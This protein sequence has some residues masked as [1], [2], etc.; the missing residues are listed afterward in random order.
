[1]P[2]YTFYDSEM[3]HE[4]EESMSM[5]EREAFLKDNSHIQ[6]RITTMNIV[7]GTGGMKNDAGWNEQLSRI[8]EAHPSSELASNKGDKSIKAA[9]TRQAVEKWRKKRAADTS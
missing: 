4:F 5:S 6:Q 9:R 1:M 3:D 2:T 7:R 8:A